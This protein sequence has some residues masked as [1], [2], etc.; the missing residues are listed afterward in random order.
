[1]NFDTGLL[2]EDQAYVRGLLEHGKALCGKHR[3]DTVE[4]VQRLEVLE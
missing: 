4:S 2:V 3:L 1:M